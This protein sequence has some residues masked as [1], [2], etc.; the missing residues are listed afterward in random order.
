MSEQIFQGAENMQKQPSMHAKHQANDKLI[1]F[2]IYIP[3][4]VKYM[5]LF[6]CYCQPTLL[7]YNSNKINTY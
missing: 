7:S 6:K 1:F 4:T 3:K 5:G 2:T